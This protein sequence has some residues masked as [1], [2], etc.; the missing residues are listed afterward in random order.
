[1]SGF[2]SGHYSRPSYFSEDG[3]QFTEETYDLADDFLGIELF[4]REQIKGLV[5]DGMLDERYNEEPFIVS[6]GGREYLGS[7][8]IEYVRHLTDKYFEQPMQTFTKSDVNM[9]RN[10]TIQKG[11]TI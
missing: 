11:E 2:G 8:E 3:R 4:D 10:K 5:R 1:M 9:D 7:D 6:T